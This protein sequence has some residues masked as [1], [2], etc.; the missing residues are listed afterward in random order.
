MRGRLLIIALT[1]LAYVLSRFGLAGWRTAGRRPVRLN[2]SI[3]SSIGGEST[4]VERF[5]RLDVP[6]LCS[7]RSSAAQKRSSSFFRARAGVIS[8]SLISHST[9]QSFRILPVCSMQSGGYQTGAHSTIKQWYHTEKNGIHPTLPPIT[10]ET[11]AGAARSRHAGRFHNQLPFLPDGHMVTIGNNN[12]F[13][14]EDM[15][16]VVARCGHDGGEVRF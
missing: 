7:R 10:H 2:I 15:S 8:S 16:D 14:Y 9:T 13:N 3:R 4:C 11:D 5:W 6:A 1:L 12:E